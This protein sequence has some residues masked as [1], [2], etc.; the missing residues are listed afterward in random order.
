LLTHTYA[1]P[2]PYT[3]V[4]TATNCATATAAVTHTLTVLP[5]CDPVQIVTVTQVVS[6]CVVALG[7]EVSGTAPFTY[8]WAAGP[9]T[10]TLP[11][12]AFD[13]GVSGTYTVT[14]TVGNCGGEDVWLG[15]VQVE[16]P[17]LGWRVYLPLVSR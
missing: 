14:L 6:G 10:S 2:G 3:V 17:V 5:A 1:L 13:F 15:P 9:L 12:P 8:L 4:L 11:A 7:A 16:C